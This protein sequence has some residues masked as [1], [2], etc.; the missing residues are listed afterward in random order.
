MPANAIIIKRHSDR[1]KSATW[2]VGPRNRVG[3]RHK[4]MSLMETG[5]AATAQKRLADTLRPFF[6][7]LLDVV[8]GPISDS[9]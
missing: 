7:S 9:L 6:F 5:P 1:E 2:N 3:P 8:V 4:E